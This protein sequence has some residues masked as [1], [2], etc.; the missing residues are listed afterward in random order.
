MLLVL[1]RYRLVAVDKEVQFAGL[2]PARRA[3]PF[4]EVGPLR[5]DHVCVPGCLTVGEDEPVAAL[6]RRPLSDDGGVRDLDEEHVALTVEPSALLTFSLPPHRRS[7]RPRRAF[8]SRGEL[9]REATVRASPVRGIVI[10][11]RS[12]ESW[13]MPVVEDEPDAIC[14][15]PERD[16]AVSPPG[17][18]LQRKLDAFY[19]GV[20][21]APSIGEVLRGVRGGLVW[22]PMAGRSDEFENWVKHIERDARVRGSRL[23]QHF[24]G[25]LAGCSDSG[26]WLKE[27]R[28][29]RARSRRSWR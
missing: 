15:P 12:W 2:N 25:A 13:L 29:N 9:C 21:P 8:R 26:L 23:V 24:D 7:L 14:S 5:A 1:E 20:G 19:E 11:V 22:I 18:G 3:A 6:L 28:A 16:K 17:G 27:R 4:S 10:C